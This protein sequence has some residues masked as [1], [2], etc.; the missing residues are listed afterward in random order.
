MK[1]I[2]S[3]GGTG[4]HIFPAIAIANQLKKL[5]PDIEIL[6][7]GASDRMEMERV[8]AAGYEIE[9]LHIQG[10]NRKNMLKNIRTF[11]KIIDSLKQS[12]KIVKRFQPDVAIGVGGYASGP[13]LYA[14]TK[15][16]IP[17]LIQEQNSYAGITN[18]LLSKRVQKICV[19]YDNMERFFPVDKI[20]KTGNPVRQE[21]TNLNVSKEEALEYF[22]L[23]TRDKVILVVGGSLGARTVNQSI[24]RSLNKLNQSNVQVI[25]QTG[26]SYFKTAETEASGYKKVK[27]FKFISRM[28]MAFVA[29]DIII[30][31]AGAS[32]ISELCLVGKPCIFVPS[33]NVSEDHQTKNALALVEK[34]AAEM[35]KDDEADEK[36]INNVLHLLKN[37]DRMN[38]L[39]ENIL[40]LG[41]DNSAELIV[42]EILKLV[43][44]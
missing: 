5:V 31:R 33:P 41:I 15:L 24:C 27:V 7:V 37:T 42:N 34:N 22:G 40:K 26:I 38:E 9:G 1:A 4:G 29:A 30:S 11:M 36:L 2:I 14:A 32:T 23:N 10:F 18:K 25:W 17:S 39:S 20:I 35:V 19:A 28:D 16:G 43:K 3:G 12:K 8:P 6:F 21:I 13:L 44:K